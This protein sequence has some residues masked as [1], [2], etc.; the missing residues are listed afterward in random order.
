MLS[1]S[2]TSARHAILEPNP[3][4][5]GGRIRHTQGVDAELKDLPVRSLVLMKQAASRHQ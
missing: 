2:Q 5:A 4:P 1:N 3:L